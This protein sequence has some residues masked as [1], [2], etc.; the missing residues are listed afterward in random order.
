MSESNEKTRE[1]RCMVCGRLRSP[2]GMRD[3]VA[4]AP[5]DQ[6]ASR[7]P[8]ESEDYMPGFWQSAGAAV[9]SEVSYDDR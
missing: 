7:F 6:R 8:H 2:G 9:V 3:A 1:G 5:C 4:H